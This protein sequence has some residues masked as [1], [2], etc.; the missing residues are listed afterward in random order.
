MKKIIAYKNY[1]KDFVSKLS[2]E[3]ANKLRRALDLFK[4][5]DR[6]PRHY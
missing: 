2:K 5:E 1:F 3:E 4:V 6:I